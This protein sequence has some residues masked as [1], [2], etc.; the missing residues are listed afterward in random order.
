M[1]GDYVPVGVDYCTVHDGIRNEDES[2]CDFAKDDEEYGDDGEPRPCVLHQLAYRRPRT[3]A[4]V[5]AT[6]DALAD[7][8]E[9]AEPL[10][11]AEWKAYAEACGFDPGSEAP[12]PGTTRKDAEG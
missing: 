1:S 3:F 6:Q 12:A 7:R 11:D 5:V 10:T 8:F 2:V 9:Q 4:E